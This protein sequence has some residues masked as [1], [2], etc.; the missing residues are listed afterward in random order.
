MVYVWTYSKKECTWLN[1]ESFENAV[2]TTF[3]TYICT[4]VVE[5]FLV[6][7]VS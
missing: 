7:E 3:L 2:K 5:E 1:E 6:N 4:G